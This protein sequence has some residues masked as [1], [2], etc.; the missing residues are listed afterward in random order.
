M[1]LLPWDVWGGMPGPGDRITD[2]LAEQLDQVAAITANCDTA[3]DSRARYGDEQ[4]RVPARV[5]N[6]LRQQD[7][8]VI[9]IA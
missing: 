5:Y 1:E 7:E 3:A 6:F 8:P 4:F 9:E 2:A